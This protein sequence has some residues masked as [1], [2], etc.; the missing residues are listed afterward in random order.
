ME[1]LKIDVPNNKLS[2]LSANEQILFIQLG[3]ALNEINILQKCSIYAGW[4]LTDMNEVEKGANICQ[5]LFFIR[6]LAGKL[7]EAEKILNNPVIKIY[8]NKLSSKEE[9]NLKNFRKCMKMYKSPE[10]IRNKLAFHNDREE[11]K[12][13][14]IRR[15]CDE[16]L[17]MII[18]KEAG[19]CFYSFSDVIVNFTILNYIDPNDSLKAMQKL[20]K[21]IVEDL[22]GWFQSV[23]G[24]IMAIIAKK[25]GLNKII[26]I[27]LKHPLPIDTF[28]LPYFLI[29]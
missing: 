22:A 19:N 3:N 10:F 18:G 20:L 4:G 24:E 2:S 13:E 15:A 26:K 25:A 12:K 21:E 17:E 7:Y 11:I 16:N 1:L 6:M 14:L 23:G 29:K 28:K 9:K 5:S 8:F 27:K